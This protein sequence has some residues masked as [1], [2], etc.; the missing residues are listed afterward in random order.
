MTRVFIALFINT[1]L[2][3]LAVNADFSEFPFA[4]E[5]LFEGE[6]KDFTRD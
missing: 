1:G 3:T 5:Y 2:I 4:S 6:F